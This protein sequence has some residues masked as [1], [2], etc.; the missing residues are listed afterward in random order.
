MKTLN[1]EKLYRKIFNAKYTT[2]GDSV[3]YC[4]QEEEKTLYILF[5][6]SSSKV[7]WKHNF[8]FWK[9]PYKDMTIKYRVHSGFL[10]CWKT[11]EKI[12]INKIKEVDENGEYKFNRIICSGWSHGGALTVFCHECV[13]FYRPDIRK[14]CFS[15]SFEGPRVYGGF[16]VKKSLRE[17]WAHFFQVINDKD[18][19]THVPPKIF[20]FTHVGN[21]IHIGRDAGLGYI[22]SHC[23]DGIFQSLQEIKI[24][25]ENDT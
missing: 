7:D 14:Q 3:D 5:E 22:K 11:V 21:V 16:R 1:L 4:F 6:E 2:V 18:I 13:W 17:R 20:G 25:E 9:R 8:A 15:V 23:S 19:V 10:K 12:I 24:G